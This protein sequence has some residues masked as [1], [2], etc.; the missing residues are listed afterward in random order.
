MPLDTLSLARSRQ[1]RLPSSA[2]PEEPVSREDGGAGRGG[3]SGCTWCRMLSCCPELLLVKLNVESG[4]GT[5]RQDNSLGMRNTLENQY[6]LQTAGR[7][8][9]Q[10]STAARPP[11]RKLSGPYGPPA[12]LHPRPQ[13]EQTRGPGAQAPALVLLTC[14]CSL[15]EVYSHT[16]LF[17]ETSLPVGV[18]AWRLEH[19]RGVSEHEGVSVLTCDPPRCCLVLQIPQISYASTAPELS[20]DR[21]YDFFSRVVP[22]DSFQAQAMVDI[23]KALGWNYVST[24]ASEGSYGEKGVESFTQIS[25]EAGRTR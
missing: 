7:H 21:R 20:D 10:I 22:P 8:S 25:K 9:S 17:R 18:P 6:L 14:A 3:C 4:Q 11:N 2:P 1:A 13:A 24:L 16:L 5:S 23:V 15:L 12:I 19:G